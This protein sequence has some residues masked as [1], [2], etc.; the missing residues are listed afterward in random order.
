MYMAHED[1]CCAQSSQ[2]RSSQGPPCAPQAPLGP[3]M[4]WDGNS[5]NICTAK[6]KVE[7]PTCCR[8]YIC[9][10]CPLARAS[11]WQHDASTLHSLSMRLHNT[12]EIKPP[13]IISH[14]SSSACEILRTESR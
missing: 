8:L 2:P 10:K 13:E 4:R 9:G 6:L 14:H 3:G 7:W 12:P 1:A 11:A 5:E